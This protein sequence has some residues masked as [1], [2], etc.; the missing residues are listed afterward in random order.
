MCDLANEIVTL[1]LFSY[2]QHT[3]AIPIFK[4]VDFYT[5][6]CFVAFLN[7]QTF[8]YYSP[9]LDTQMING[10]LGDKMII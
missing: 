3:Y 5:V 10:R 8:T 7:T 2:S 6:Y 9:F 4:R 1:A